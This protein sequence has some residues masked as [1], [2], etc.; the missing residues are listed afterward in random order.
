MFVSPLRRYQLDRFNLDYNKR[1]VNEKLDYILQLGPRKA[2]KP[3][4]KYREKLIKRN[5]IELVKEQQELHYDEKIYAKNDAYYLGFWQSYKYFDQ[6]YEE[7]KRQIVL[8]EQ[9]GENAQKYINEMQNG[10]SVACHI[11]RTDYDREVNN[12]CIDNA[13]YENALNIMEQKIGKFELYIFTDDKEFVKEHFKLKEYTIVENTSDLEDFL[14]MQ[15]CKNHII[16]N[17]TFSWWGA[18]LAENKGGVVIA[19]VA[20]MWTRDFYLPQWTCIE[21]SVG[22]QNW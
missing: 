16:A 3:R 1:L 19:P 20:N 11:R 21:T 14:L 5:E 2:K 9:I 22:K 15:K 6:Y 8:K 13:Y 4:L 17:S 18:Y 10:K 12:V 7:I